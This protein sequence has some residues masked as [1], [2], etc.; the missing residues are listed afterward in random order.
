MHLCLKQLRTIGARLIVPY[1]W[2]PVSSGL[3]LIQALMTR[4]RNYIELGQLVATAQT[5]CQ[6]KPDDKS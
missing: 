1:S 2:S 5:L 3:R 6:N 4:S